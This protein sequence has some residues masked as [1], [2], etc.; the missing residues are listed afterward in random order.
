MMKRPTIPMPTGRKAAAKRI[1]IFQ[2]T[3]EGPDSHTK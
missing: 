2:K 3:T 1:V